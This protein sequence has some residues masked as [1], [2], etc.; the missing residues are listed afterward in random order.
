[1]TMA[2]TKNITLMLTDA[3][4][5]KP[6]SPAYRAPARPP[7]RPPSAKAMMR[8]YGTSAPMDAAASWSSRMARIRRPS[9]VRVMKAAKQM[10]RTRTSASR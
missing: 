7:Y 8:R 1:M 10:P 3:G 9:L 2:S 4:A 5:T 6:T